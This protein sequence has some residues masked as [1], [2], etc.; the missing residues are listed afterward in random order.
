MLEMVQLP[1]VMSLELRTIT[2]QNS[3]FNEHSEMTPF[4]TFLRD[5]PTPSSGQSDEYILTLAITKCFVVSDIEMADSHFASMLQPEI[6][7]GSSGVPDPLRTP[8]PDVKSSSPSINIAPRDVLSK[9]DGNS[10]EAADTTIITAIS[11]PSRLKTDFPWSS[12]T[13]VGWKMGWA[14]YIGAPEASNE[15][16]SAGKSCLSERPSR[17]DY[18]RAIES[19]QVEQAVAT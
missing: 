11:G 2:P 8:F 15:P 19:L 16:R 14:L 1:I 7:Y 9:E 12:Q 10:T 3:S 5:T 18:C 13:T 6:T 4:V 17:A